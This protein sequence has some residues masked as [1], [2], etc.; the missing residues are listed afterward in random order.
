MQIEKTLHEIDFKSAKTI[1]KCTNKKNKWKILLSNQFG[2]FQK[3][4]ARGV[5]EKISI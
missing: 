1:Y 5:V 4:F 2:I 3:Y